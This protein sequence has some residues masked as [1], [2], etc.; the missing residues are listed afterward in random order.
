MN[1]RGR[2]LVNQVE[3]N[4]K[5]GLEIRNQ[6]NQTIIKLDELDYR[7]QKEFINSL[8]DKHGND[9]RCNTIRAWALSRYVI[10]SGPLQDLLFGLKKL[11]LKPSLMDLLS[12]VKNMLVKYEA[13][14]LKFVEKNRE[15]GPTPHNGRHVM[16]CA[17]IFLKG[18]LKDKNLLKFYDILDSVT[19]KLNLK[20]RSDFKI[21]LPMDKRVWEQQVRQVRTY[22]SSSDYVFP[23]VI[24]VWTLCYFTE[25]LSVES[26]TDY[27]VLATCEL[28]NWPEEI[29]E[30][31]FLK[32]IFPQIDSFPAGNLY[33]L[34]KSG[35]SIYLWPQEV[36]RVIVE[37]LFLGSVFELKEPATLCY[38]I[39]LHFKEKPTI[40]TEQQLLAIIPEPIMRDF[41][42]LPTAF[43]SNYLKNL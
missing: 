43:F 39:I 14:F 30:E 40:L 29:K 22:I 37:S 25:E 42:L 18:T 36:R 27:Y 38:K 35:I 17:L 41:E 21:S 23:R 1:K 26:F 28:N 3:K 10:F 13:P 32:C 4:A 20:L 6:I 33:L 9:L 11:N 8:K 5:I 24:T 31:R 19:K 12:D 16:I 34:L 15:G 7:L 2:P